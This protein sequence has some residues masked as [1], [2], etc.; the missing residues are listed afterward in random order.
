MSIMYFNFFEGQSHKKR[1][2]PCV[3]ATKLFPDIIIVQKIVYAIVPQLVNL[4]CN[5]LQ[6][7]AR[8]VN[9]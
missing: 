3:I 2:R 5:S 4:T 1:V 8:K 6:S 7:F 9:V